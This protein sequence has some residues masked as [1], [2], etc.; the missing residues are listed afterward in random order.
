MTGWC[1]AIPALLLSPTGFLPQAIAEER[2]DEETIALIKT[3]GFQRSEVMDTLFH[4]TDAKGPRL[5]GSEGFERAARFRRDRLAGSG[6][7]RAPIESF[8]SPVPGWELEDLLA[9]APR[10]ILRSARGPSEGLSRSSRTRSNTRASRTTRT[11]TS[12]ITSG[13]MT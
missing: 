12:T 8:P 6:L 7:A 9:R 5:H 4:L 11:R 1:D 3:E 10:A 13:R 2:V